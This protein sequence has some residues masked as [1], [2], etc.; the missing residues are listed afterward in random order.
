VAKKSG[1]K[2][3]AKAKAPQ[4]RSRPRAVDPYA[5][6][7]APRKAANGPG[8]KPASKSSKKRLK[9]LKTP[10]WSKIVLSI[11]LLLTLTSGVAFAAVRTVTGEVENTFETI[12]LLGDAGKT[13]AQGGK[14]LD[15]A[16]DML[17]LG[18][19]IRDSQSDKNST[20]AD[21]ILILHIPATHDQA[22]LM[23]LPRD[24]MVDIP[25]WPASK[26]PGG[27]E[28]I[29]EAFYWGAQ[30]GGGWDNGMA[31]TA[32][33]VSKLTGIT[34]DGAATIDFGGF[35][36]IVETLGTV[37][38]CIEADTES[39]HRY[40]VKGQVTYVNEDT[41]KDKGYKPFVHLKGCRDMAG[42]EA[43]DYSRIRYDLPDG[44]YGRQRHQ[45]QLMKAIAKKA[46]SAGTLT[47]L[48][49]LRGLMQAAGQTMRLD[50]NGVDI[51][52]FIFTLKDL[53]GADL[54]LLKTNNGNFNSINGG[55]A[56]TLDADTKA[57]L[58]AASEDK[59]GPFLL[60]NPGLVNNDG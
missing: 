18:I 51:N 25:K 57:M 56:E 30:H 7:P 15:G 10:L 35:E 41:A 55:G 39:L 45:Q 2:S 24:L 3:S 13:E 58:K 23:S 6:D 47:D 34:F 22:Y 11:G 14:N 31:L 20:R 32:N 4:Q 43:L 54:V 27:R 53:A 42:W 46:T 60:E 17:L 50:T 8:R 9:R 36:R 49:K 37:P 29:N 21:S 16:I 38:M 48:G 28:K 44:D 33:T 12:D 19:D 1:G 40:Y 26:Y 59:L 52:D 5:E